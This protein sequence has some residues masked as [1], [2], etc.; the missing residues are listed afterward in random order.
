[1]KMDS[2]IEE[3]FTKEEE[4]KNSF[5]YASKN[6]HITIVFGIYHI[7]NYFTINEFCGQMHLN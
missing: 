4:K 6:I 2:F 3:Y 1:M 7:K 5:G